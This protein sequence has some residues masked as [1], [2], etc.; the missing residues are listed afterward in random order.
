M[1]VSMMQN[2]QARLLKRSLD[3]FLI[4]ESNFPGTSK[5]ELYQWHL[6]PGAFQRLNPPWNPAKLIVPHPGVFEGAKVA[7]K[8]M[9]ISWLL[10]HHD[11][12]ENHQFCDSQLKG[13]F[14]SYTHTHKFLDSGVLQ[15]EIGFNALGASFIEKELRRVFNYRHQVLRRD[16]DQHK[17]S[18]KLKFLITGASGLVGSNLS[19]FLSSGGHS[20]ETLSIKDEKIDKDLGSYDCIVHLAGENIASG[21]WTKEKKELILKSRVKTTSLL[22]DKIRLLSSKPYIISASAIGYYGTRGEFNEESPKGD[23]F[24]A[25]VVS[26]W[27]G[28]W[29]DL[30]VAKLR[31]G[32]IMTPFGGALKKM[33]PA[34]RLGLGGP[35]GND[36]INW[37]S[38]DDVIYLINR[39][40]QERK[41][42]GPLNVSQYSRNFSEI[43]GNVLNRPSFLRVP[44]IALKILFGEMANETILA[45]QRVRSSLSFIDNDLESY[46]RFCLGKFK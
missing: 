44:E 31:F 35:I 18:T 27:E 41:F 7:L 17:G 11:V 46:L 21:R 12:I 26:Q 29:G 2:A 32:V 5:E 45:E 22:R 39:L 9:G 6:R 16:L 24:L 3:K 19:A 10:K 13:P 15:D 30:D 8:V 20:V 36:S 38:L 4:F 33:L 40:S 23:G 34:Y 1:Q 14:F 25:E 28:A 37:V 43:L 42:A